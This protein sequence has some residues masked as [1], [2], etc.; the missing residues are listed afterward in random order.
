M[1]ETKRV[2]F[3]GRLFLG[4]WIVRLLT[5]LGIFLVLV[6][7]T[8]F[9]S[10]YAR[11][12]AGPWNDPSG[13]ILIVLGS[14]IVTPDI[15]GPSSFWRSVYALRVYREGHFQRI[16]LSGAGVAPLMRDF[17]LFQGVPADRILLENTSLSTRE[18]ALYTRQLLRNMPGRQVLLTS[19]YHMWRAFRAFRKAGLPVV[20]RPIPD[21][22]KRA[23]M[24]K[25]RW[26]V[27]LDESVETGKILYYW[28]RNWI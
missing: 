10:W 15:I 21:A 25:Y 18:N 28:I 9:V 5:T 26:D 7:A 4:R 22:L 17:L 16:V 23:G 20:P 19:D 8:P 13:D 24:W 6:T 12:L 1:T 11:L 14:D 27:F 2:R 3:P